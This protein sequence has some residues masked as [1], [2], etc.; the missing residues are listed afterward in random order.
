[1]GAE[2]SRSQSTVTASRPL[3][4]GSGMGMKREG[5]VW[6]R[7]KAK[8]DPPLNTAH[9]E[10]PCPRGQAPIWPQI[11]GPLPSRSSS[12]T[13]PHTHIQATHTH[14]R[15]LWVKSQKHGM[16]EVEKAQV[17]SETRPTLS[18]HSQTR[19]PLLESSLRTFW[20]SDFPSCQ[21]RH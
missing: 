11:A 8:W 17:L 14:T 16:S 13:H 9:A 21:H 1:M 20:T 15:P 19:P 10:V 6:S 18:T 2:P 7:E 5:Q 3:P 4:P 12:S